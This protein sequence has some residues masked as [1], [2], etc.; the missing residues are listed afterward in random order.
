MK[1][2][3]LS[4]MAYEEELRAQGLLVPEATPHPNGNGQTTDVDVEPVRNTPARVGTMALQPQ[5]HERPKEHPPPI[6]LSLSLDLYDP[7]EDGS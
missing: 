1:R 4:H 2:G 7:D 3:A 6:S 5:H